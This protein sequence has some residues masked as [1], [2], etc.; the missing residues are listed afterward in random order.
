MDMFYFQSYI[1][2]NITKLRAKPHSSVGSIQDL[3]T[4]GPWFDPLAQ[5][6]FFPRIDDY[7]CDTIRSSRTAVHCFENGYVG[8][9]PVALEKYSVEYW[10]KQLRIKGGNACNQHFLLFPYCFLFT[11]STT[12]SIILTNFNPLAYNDNF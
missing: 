8:K 10:L 1:D 11:L 9:Q 6:I 2:Q 7:H 12:N 3:R 4:G 5:S